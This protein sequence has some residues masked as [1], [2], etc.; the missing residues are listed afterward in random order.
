MRSEKNAEAKVNT[1][2]LDRID[3]ILLCVPSANGVDF[4]SELFSGKI[5][6][7]P[8]SSTIEQ[9]EVKD[10]EYELTGSGNPGTSTN[11]YIIKT[12]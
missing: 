4:A 8:E 6:V 2:I 3:S 12:N 5:D 9:N 1:D 11:P 10:V 7:K